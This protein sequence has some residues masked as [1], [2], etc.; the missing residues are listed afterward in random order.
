M[1]TPQAQSWRVYRGE[2]AEIVLTGEDDTNPTG[3][4]LVFTISAYPTQ[5]PVTLAVTDVTVGG[6]GPYTFTI[7]LTR[8]ETSDLT[9]DEYHADLWRTDSGNNVR[10]AGGRIKVLNPVRLPA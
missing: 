5:T 3:W 6:A 8:A 4:A 1:S 9:A 10:L 2:D 7:P